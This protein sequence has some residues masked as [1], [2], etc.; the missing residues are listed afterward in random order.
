[1]VPILSKMLCG[2]DWALAQRDDEDV[3]PPL[4]ALPVQ[5]KNAGGSK[6]T[7]FKEKYREAT[8]ISEYHIRLGDPGK[9]FF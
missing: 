3:W 2:G 8:T 1:M 6:Y 4:E 7:H 5:L 9:M